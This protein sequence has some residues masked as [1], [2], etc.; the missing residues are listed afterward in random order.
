[1]KRITTSELNERLTSGPVALFDVRGDV[2][3]ERGHIPGA[4]TAPLGS[5]GFRVAR[6]MNPDSFVAVYSE[7]GDCPLAHEAAERLEGLKLSNVHVYED[8]IDGW[9]AAGLDVVESVHAKK[10]TRGVV[11]DCR[12]I[13]VDRERAY[14]GAFKGKPTAVEGAGG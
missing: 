13:I 2:V 5:L 6:V 9:S 10:H 3:Y 14:N 12:S 11:E 4:M 8:G 7:G 1:M